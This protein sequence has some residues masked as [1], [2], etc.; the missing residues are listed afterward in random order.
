[1]QTRWRPHSFNHT[2]SSVSLN[3]VTDELKCRL[4]K[5][6]AEQAGITS[7]VVPRDIFSKLEQHQQAKAG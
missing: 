6:K 2:E 4:K 5:K 7:S 1:V 3:S